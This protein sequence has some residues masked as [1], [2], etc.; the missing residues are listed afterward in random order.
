MREMHDRLDGRV[1]MVIDVVGQVGLVAQTIGIEAA[2]EGEPMV[3]I[4][5]CTSWEGSDWRWALDFVRMSET[6]SLSPAIG[7]FSNAPSQGS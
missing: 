4:V 3:G 6:C 5:P 2:Q 1:D 7:R